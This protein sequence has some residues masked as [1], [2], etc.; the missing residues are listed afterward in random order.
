MNALH[1]VA[2]AVTDIAESLD[3]FRGQF[4]VEMLY[5]DDNW[6][7]VPFDNTARACVQPDPHPPHVAIERGN[8]ESYGTF[9]PRRDGTASVYI[10]NPWGNASEIMK[11]GSRN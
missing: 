7:L 5:A 3:W 2:N 4:E 10:R 1:N 9:A 6:A 11:R 8:A